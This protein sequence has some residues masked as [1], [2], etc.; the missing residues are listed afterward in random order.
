MEDKLIYTLWLLSHYGWDT[1]TYELVLNLAPRMAVDSDLIATIPKQ[2]W[3]DA[4]AALINLRG[5]R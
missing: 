3:D 2:E 1:P 5:K 4:K